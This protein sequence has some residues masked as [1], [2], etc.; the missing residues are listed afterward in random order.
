MRTN[1]RSFVQMTLARRWIAGFACGATVAVQGS[2]HLRLRFTREFG[3]MP[4]PGQTYPPK[5]LSEI[6]LLARLAVRI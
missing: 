1:N 6:L 5:L 3:N 2:L 4:C